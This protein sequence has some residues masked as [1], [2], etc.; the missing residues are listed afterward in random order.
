MCDAMIGEN[1]SQLIAPIDA[2][3]LLY[4]RFPSARRDNE[5]IPLVVILEIGFTEI[6][7]RNLGKKRDGRL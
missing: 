5:R 6:T 4:G 3:A 1:D 2:R 7:L